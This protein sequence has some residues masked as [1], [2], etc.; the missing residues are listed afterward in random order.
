IADYTAKMTFGQMS[1]IFFMVA[2]PLF[3]A[4]LGVKKMILVGMLA[5]VARYA[6]FAVG[7]ADQAH[8]VVSMLL[9]GV[10]L[11][12][13]CYDFFFVTGQIYVDKAAPKEIRGSA[14]GLL[15]LV[16]L[17]AGMFI[18]AKIAGMIKEHYTSDIADWQAIWMWPTGMAAVVFVLFGLLFRDPPKEDDTAGE[19][20]DD[21]PG[22]AG[23]PSSEG[24]EPETTG[25][26]TG[27]EE[28]GEDKAPPVM[29]IEGE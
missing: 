14:Q 26:E 29:P 20:S 1:E 22:G 21:E 18:G 27:T 15:V 7:A 12:G 8:P 28:A 25:P 2:M 11:H 23:E 10:I 19:A 17:G 9:A 13:I 6:L 24:D 4:R 5:W 3:F 16:T